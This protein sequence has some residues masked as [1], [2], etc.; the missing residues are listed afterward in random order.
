M[1]AKDLTGMRF[2]RLVV[3]GRQPNHIAPCGQKKAMFLCKCDCGNEI[4]VQAA[5]LKSG[6]TKSCGCFRYDTFMDTRKTN[7][8]H[9]LSHTRLH[10]VW[11]SMKNRCYLPSNPN[12]A[13]YGGRGVTICDEWR[14]S[15]EAFHSWAMENGYDENAPYGECTLDRIDVNGNYSP[16]NCKWATA[17][18]QANNR[19]KKEGSTVNGNNQN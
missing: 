17:K 6:N 19:R 10:K 15:F 3:L 8:T 11:S 1:K 5:N 12:Y 2:G 9:G 18:E 13:N 4:V 14:N 16:N 7:K